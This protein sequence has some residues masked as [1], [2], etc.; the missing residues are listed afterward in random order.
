M[1]EYDLTVVILHVHFSTGFVYSFRFVS[2]NSV[3]Q[4]LSYIAR[5]VCLHK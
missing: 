2:Q 3:G 4:L 5:K 1:E